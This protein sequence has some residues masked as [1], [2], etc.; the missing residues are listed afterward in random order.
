VN[1][2]LILAGVLAII[3]PLQARRS[4]RRIHDML[5]ARGNATGRFDRAMARWLRIEVL[6]PAVGLVCIVV[7]VT[8]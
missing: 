2:A 3:W 8:N 6:G 4:I 7:G 1:I 5:E